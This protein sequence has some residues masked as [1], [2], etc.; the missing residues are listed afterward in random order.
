MSSKAGVIENDVLS[1]VW[2]RQRNKLKSTG[3]K[4][5]ALFAVQGVQGQSPRQ[6]QTTRRWVTLPYAVFVF[7]AQGF[8]HVSEKPLLRL[9][10]FRVFAFV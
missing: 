8:P 7:A 9:L 6:G 5:G 1:F 2:P 3:S 10:F 4:G